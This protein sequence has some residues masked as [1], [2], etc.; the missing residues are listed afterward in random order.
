MPVIHLTQK[1][2]CFIYI[3]TNMVLILVCIKKSYLN[4]VDG[5]EKK[6]PYSAAETQ[7]LVRFLLGF[8]ISAVLTNLKQNVHHK[9]HLPERIKTGSG[10]P[11][12]LLFS[13][14]KTKHLPG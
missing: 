7:F 1:R 3:C 9:W 14:K 12:H 8:K 4:I 10:Q 11:P 6:P 5:S 2:T 13:R